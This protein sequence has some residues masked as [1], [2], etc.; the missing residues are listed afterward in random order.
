MFGNSEELGED[1][2]KFNPER[3]LWVGLWLIW[4]GFK[5]LKD[6]IHS[7]EVLLNYITFRES[8]VRSCPEHPLPDKAK[9]VH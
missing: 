2:L 6:H 5:L 7:L 1:K 9:L 4:T 8:S 3:S